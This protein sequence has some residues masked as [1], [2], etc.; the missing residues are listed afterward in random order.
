MAMDEHGK[1]RVPWDEKVKPRVPWDEK[2][3]PSV[4]WDEAAAK[5]LG[6]LMPKWGKRGRGGGTPGPSGG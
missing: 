2:V 4:P 1:P 5:I 3:E 6:P